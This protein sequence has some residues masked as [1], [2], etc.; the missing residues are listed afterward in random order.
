MPCAPIAINPTDRA[1][2]NK[3]SSIKPAFIGKRRTV[4]PRNSDCPKAETYSGSALIIEKNG[5]LYS[6]DHFVYPEHNLGNVREMSIRDMV[7]S[8][9]QRKF[10]Q[11]KAD[12]L[13]R[14][15]L[16]CD[17]KFACN[18]GCPK[19]RFES[20]PHG[21]AGLNYLCK[22]YKMY[23]GHVGPYMEVMANLLRQRQPAT[24]VMDWVRQRD[25]ARAVKPASEPGRNDPCPCG[26]GQKFKRCCGNVAVAGR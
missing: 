16:E 2:A 12:T 21:E 1:N 6:C 19:H 23:F 15:C 3:A 14:Y 17:Y 8:P 26:S 22:G 24:G 9:Q 25:E 4:G 11:D 10:G 18:G 20:T 7:A 13:P 5:D